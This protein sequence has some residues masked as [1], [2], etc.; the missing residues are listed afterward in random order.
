MPSQHTAALTAVSAPPPS[1]A[2]DL[3]T[4]AE[5]VRLVRLQPATL[6]R[7]QRGQV[8]RVVRGGPNNPRGQR[9]LVRRADVLRL[10]ARPADGPA[11][12]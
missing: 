2:D 1:P 3:L 11:A 4:V 10:M 7:I 9:H 6:R 12:A 5:A 8:P